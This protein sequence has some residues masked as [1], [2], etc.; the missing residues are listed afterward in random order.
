MTGIGFPRSTTSPPSVRTRQD[1]GPDGSV[2]ATVRDLRGRRGMSGPEDRPFDGL[3]SHDVGEGGME[4]APGSGS[5][6]GGHTGG[7]FR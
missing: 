4:E 3:S 2:S 1:D 6:P 7:R 5:A